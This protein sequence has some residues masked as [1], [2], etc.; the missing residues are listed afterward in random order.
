MDRQIVYPGQIPLETDL[1]HTNKYAMVALAKLAAAILGTTTVVNGLACVPTDPASMQVTVNPGEMYALMSIDASGYSSLP[2][3]TAHN[4]LKQGISLDAVTLDCPAP[5]TAGHSI[6]YLVQ[7]AYQDADTDL[8]T[9][10]YYNASNPTQAW[11][12]PNNSG[13]PQATARKGIVAVAAKPGASAPT[14]TQTTPAPDVG[15]TG[16]WVVT[17]ASGQTTITSANIA[18]AQNAPILPADLLR[19]IQQNALTTAVDT[20][21]ANTYVVSYSP[22]IRA[23]TNGMVLW[24][25]AK[26]ANT[27]AS[28][29]NVN[30]LGA[31][32]IVGPSQVALQGGE[33]VAKAKCQVIYRADI[34]SFILAVS[35]GGSLQ[36]GR[37]LRTTIYTKPAAT[38]LVSVDGGTPT[39]TGA[40]T[41]TPLAATKFVEVEVQGAG[42]GGAGARATGASQ[43]SV[44]SG[45]GGGAYGRGRYTSA[46]ASGVA[47]T[48]GAGGVGGTGAAGTA[49]GSSS[50]GALLSAP[51]GNAG[52]VEG[53][54]A[55]PLYAVTAGNT[56]ASGGFVSSN[57]F[58]GDIHYGFDVN[59]A[60]GGDGGGTPFGGGG[61]RS[62][63]GAGSAGTS[64]GSGGGGTVTT[65]SLAAR[66]GGNG[67][68]GIIIVKEYA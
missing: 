39:S 58:N 29:L 66:T 49:G 5:A 52:Q 25:E 53:P 54:S 4:I 21:T 9:L 34:N 6:N 57:G 19:A 10:P 42:G 1:L 32:P 24:F 26:T 22:A 16:L 40:G 37:L 41:F 18:Q 46:Q 30:G 31:V 48:V 59:G 7:A 47:V 50:F 67:A 8:V 12:G 62:G 60:H 45:G 43:I 27:G 28:T 15:Y 68:G 33:I 14:G 38:Q 36:G 51:G 11:S 3:D 2:A 64:P 23:L 13:T 63:S 56:A 55:P 20:G 35:T 61:N 65:P 17:V 44:G